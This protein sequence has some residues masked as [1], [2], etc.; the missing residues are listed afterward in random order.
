[1]KY[2]LALVITGLVAGTQATD[3]FLRFVGGNTVINGQLLRLNTSTQASPGVSEPPYNPADHYSR[4]SDSVAGELRV[5]PTNPH[6]PPVPGFLALSED[7]SV[8][9]ALRLIETWH[10]ETEG[11]QVSG[12][13][14][15]R[16]R[17]GGSSLLR[18][19]EGSQN[20]WIA[21]QEVTTQ[22]VTRWVPWWVTGDVQGLGDSHEVA[23]IEVIWAK[24][25]VNSNMPG[26]TENC[27]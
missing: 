9:G 19:G 21:V 26:G 6:P 14:I 16:P 18:F 23:D 10:P 1:M 25:P 22:G 24:C 5:V 4:F 8:Q 20:R 2:S 7:E 15:Q 27:L 13:R 11:V 3:Y 12:W 17:C